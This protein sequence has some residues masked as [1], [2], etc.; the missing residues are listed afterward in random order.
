MS[1]IEWLPG[2][3]D[4]ISSTK[5][6]NI[7]GKKHY[8]YLLL[9][10]YLYLFLVFLMKRKLKKKTVKAL[11]YIK[12]NR[13]LILSIVINKSRKF[14]NESESRNIMANFN[15]SIT[16]Y[17]SF[18]QFDQFLSKN[19]KLKD[20]APGMRYFGMA[21]GYSPLKRSIDKDFDIRPNMNIKGKRPDWVKNA[22]ASTSLLSWPEP[23]K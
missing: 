8:R 11:E 10:K 2:P 15:K 20:A 1:S 4:C 14:K 13:T 23:N 21:S 3:K 12:T 22:F 9:Y 7:F 6:N 19:M 18:G 16:Q 17:N 5:S